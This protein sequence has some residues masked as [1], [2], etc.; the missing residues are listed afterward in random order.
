[1]SWANSKVG[2]RSHNYVPGT[3][4]SVPGGFSDAG[5]DIHPG[6][7]LHGI[8]SVF[9]SRVPAGGALEQGVLLLSA[10]IDERDQIENFIT[11]E[12]VEQALGHDG[13]RRFFAGGN[14][15][16]FDFGDR[17]FGERVFDQP[18]DSRRLFDDQARD[19]RPR[20]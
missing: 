2:Q 3:A 4:S 15:G 7:A 5:S 20:F 16:H 11:R 13:G 12:L 9:M 18:D 19:G 6:G 10:G 14:L 1:M 8:W 17:D